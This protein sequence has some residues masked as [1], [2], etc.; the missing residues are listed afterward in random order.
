M[1]Y[2]ENRISDQIDI[3]INRYENKFI[4]KLANRIND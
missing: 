1:S 4:P 3:K 2:D